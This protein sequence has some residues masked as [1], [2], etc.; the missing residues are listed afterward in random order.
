MGARHIPCGSFANESER[1]AT[2]YLKTRLTGT[3]GQWV[4]LTNHA[5]S[6]EAQWLSDEIDMVVIGPTGVHL[7]EIKHWN[8]A[9]LRNDQQ[10]AER[11]ADKL[12]EKARRLAG[13]LRRTCPF[14]VGFV[15]GKLLLTKAENEKFKDGTGR[16]RVHGIEVFGLSEWKDLLDVDRS[17]ILTDERVASVCRALE[18]SAKASLGDKVRV[19]GNFF[20]LEE[21]PGLRDPFRR[22]Y[23]GRRKPGRDRVILHLYDLS[24][25]KEKNALDI[26]R[27]EFDVLQ[28]LQKSPWLPSFLDSFQP[29]PSYP[30]ELYFFSY[31]DTE[32]A[33]LVD[34]AKTLPGRLLIAS[35][36]Q[37]AA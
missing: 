23:R 7:V 33:S 32:A 15:A 14:E 20:D 2:E 19:F 28:R 17:P 16:K 30:G 26:A 24:A 9:D 5:S 22:V 11:E 6:S 8:A 12:N 31:I 35:T 21:V 1:Y 3:P 4:L 13:K 37:S 29:A 25:T 34:R 10:D 27:R 36:Q 18:P